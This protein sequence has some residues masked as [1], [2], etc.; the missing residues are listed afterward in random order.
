MMS[1]IGDKSD[2]INISSSPLPN[3]QSLERVDLTPNTIRVTDEIPGSKVSAKDGDGFNILGSNPLGGEVHR[4]DDVNVVQQSH[5]KTKSNEISESKVAP[6]GDGSSIILGGDPLFDDIVSP[7][8]DGLEINVVQNPHPKTKS[9]EISER[10]VS[11][12]DRNDSNT[13]FEGK[14]VDDIIV[15]PREDALEDG[16]NVVQKPHSPPTN[17]KPKNNSTPTIDNKNKNNTP[18]YH[19][20]AVR[21]DPDVIL[22]VAEALDV[23]LFKTSPHPGWKSIKTLNSS[24]WKC[25]FSIQEEK[26]LGSQASKKVFDLVANQSSKVLPN[27][28]NNVPSDSSKSITDDKTSTTDDKTCDIDDKTPSLLPNIQSIIKSKPIIKT[29]K[30]NVKVYP[31]SDSSKSMADDKTSDIDDKT[32]SLLPKNY[33]QRYHLSPNQNPPSIQ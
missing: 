21:S 28:K 6:D 30:S 8:E 14:S 23:K 31:I 5:P 9:N 17:D 29:S 10:K 27:K 18:P 32:P 2:N 15:S 19:A 26:K 16:V 3:P 25:Q 1:I 11:A 22:N 4:L 33:Y 12:P 13:I 20:S 7:R 24:T